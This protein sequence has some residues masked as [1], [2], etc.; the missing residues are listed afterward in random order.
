MLIESRVIER[1]LQ[2]WGFVTVNP[3]RYINQERLP[4]KADI[5]PLLRQAF[6][7]SV[8]AK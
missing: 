2:F 7:F 6:E 3:K 4:R 8:S 5:Q 1:F